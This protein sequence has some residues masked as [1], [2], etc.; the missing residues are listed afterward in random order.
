MGSGGPILVGWDASE[1]ALDALA[2][3]RVLAAMMDRELVPVAVAVDRLR[4]LNPTDRDAA[5][6]RAREALGR[7][8]A[9]AHAGAARAVV[10]PSAG[11]GLY[12]VA[13]ETAASAIVL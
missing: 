9:E 13:E 1:H 6:G 2:L 5:A 3:G 8:P 10:A 4:L 11:Q 7:M 12:E